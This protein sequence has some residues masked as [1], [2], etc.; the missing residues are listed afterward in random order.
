MTQ[1]PR[2]KKH[3]HHHHAGT[4]DPGALAKFI[5]WLIKHFPKPK[6]PHPEHP[7]HPNKEPK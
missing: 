4:I 5:K 7:I 6:P 1:T 2:R 3:H